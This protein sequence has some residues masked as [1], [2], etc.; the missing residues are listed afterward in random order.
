MRSSYPGRRFSCLVE[1]LLALFLSAPISLHAQSASSQ[2]QPA[3]SPPP[4]AQSPQQST[5]PCSNGRPILKRGAQPPLPP[6]PDS[7]PDA[8]PPAASVPTHSLNPS[9]SLID[10]A[11]EAA[12]E[13]SEKLPNFICQEVMSRFTQRGREEMALDV[14]SADVIYD[15]AH[16]TYRNVKINERPTDRGMQEIGGSWSTG[17]FASTLLELLHPDTN[18]QFRSGGASSISGFSAQVY[19]FTVQRENSHWIIQSG[20]QTLTPAYGGSVWVDP[21]TARVL[22][23]EMQARNIPSDFPMDTLESTVDYSYVTIGG[24]SFLLPVRAESLGCER[25]TSECRH[26]I[27][28]FRNYHEFKADIKIGN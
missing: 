17:E 3:Q 2:S 5:P 23:I 24:T 22:R 7:P 4:A 27:I 20:S 25:G 10:R 21:K 14:V 1:V 19:D 13:F 8:V 9:E 11:R 12:F 28:D 16:E 6:C 18:A 15:N 26:N